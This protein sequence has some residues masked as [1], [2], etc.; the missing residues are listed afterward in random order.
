MMRFRNPFW[1]LPLLLTTATSTCAPLSPD[2]VSDGSLVPGYTS[3]QHVR[4][5]DWTRD[6]LLHVPRQPRYTLMGRRRRFPLVIVLHGSGA[7]GESIR[8][9][10]GMDSVAEARH[11]LVAYPDGSGEMFG[12]NSDW[13]AGQCCGG[14]HFDKVDDIAFLRRVIADVSARLPVDARRIY[15][16]GFSDGARMAYRVACEM[17]GEITA[18]AAVSGS[19]ID[20]R[21]LPSK[22]IPVIAF[23]GNADKEVR[24]NDSAYSVPSRPVPPGAGSLP[25]TLRF[26]LATDGCQRTAVGRLSPHVVRTAGVGCSA[27]VAFYAIEGGGH[28]WPVVAPASADGD[29]ESGEISASSLIA[30]FFLR[31]RK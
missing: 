23:H 1:L 27:D 13:N 19:L 16:A 28:N 22:P 17:A 4:L 20:S 25:P 8:Q 24:Y 9:Q 29:G 26:W 6:Y 3:A 15:V 2:I 21:C 30:D 12:L 11:F 7:R 10:S 18:V 31:H 5:G 14:A